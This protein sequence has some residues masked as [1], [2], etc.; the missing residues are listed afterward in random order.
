MD[1]PADIETPARAADAPVD[2]VVG[3]RP[4]MTYEEAANVV[5]CTDDLM[6]VTGPITTGFNI[7][8][9]GQ[10][11]RQGFTARLRGA[12]GGEDAPSRSWRRCRTT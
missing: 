12:A 2:D 11:L 6:V 4:G 5:L 8:T 1:C 9:Y 10:T 7:Q 3:V